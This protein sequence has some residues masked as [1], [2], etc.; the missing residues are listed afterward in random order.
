[1]DNL[2]ESRK[3]EQNISRKKK[4]SAEKTNLFSVILQNWKQRWY[5]TAI[6]EYNERNDLKQLLKKKILYQMK[7]KSCELTIIYGFCN[8]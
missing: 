2:R 1:M 7:T 4:R 5:L 3:N 6:T 8:W